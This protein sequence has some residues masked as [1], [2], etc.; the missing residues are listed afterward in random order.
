MKNK[1]AVCGKEF[2]GVYK[3]TGDFYHMACA[4]KKC[5]KTREDYQNHMRQLHERSEA[6]KNEA[7]KSLAPSS[8]QGG[9]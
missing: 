7:R 1:C 6:L 3:P 8:I 2:P 9:S 4:M 5:E